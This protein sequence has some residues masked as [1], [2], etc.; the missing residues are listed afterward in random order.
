MHPYSLVSHQLFNSKKSQ[1]QSKSSGAT[2]VLEGRGGK[3]F[4]VLTAVP[5][6]E[7]VLAVEI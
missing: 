2:K 4:L 7:D 5:C 3:A 6:H 1:Y